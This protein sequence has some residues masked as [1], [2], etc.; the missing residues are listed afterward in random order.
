MQVERIDHLHAYCEDVDAVARLFSDLFGMKTRVCDYPQFGGR[1][2]VARPPGSNRFIEWMQPIDPNGVM[3]RLIGPRD[4]GLICVNFKVPDLEAAIKEMESR[5]I[6]TVRRSELGSGRIKQAWFEY[7]DTF[8][9][10]IEMSQ[11]SGDNMFTESGN[12]L[13]Q[14]F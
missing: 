10:Q 12:P 11:Y 8:G 14:D 4:E 7:K 6:N 2:I 3:A 5:G 9:I 1:T 13:V